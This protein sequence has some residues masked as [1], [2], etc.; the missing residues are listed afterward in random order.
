MYF[1]LLDV[2]RFLSS[3]AVFFH[4]TFAFHY[5]KLGVYLFFMISGFVIYFSLHKGLKEYAIGRFLRLYPLFWICITL[6]YL[7]TLFYGNNLSLDRYLIGLAM[8]NDGKIAQ[9]IDGSYWTLTFELLFYFYIAVFVKLFSAKKLEWFYISWLLI[10]FFSF[11]LSVDQHIIAKLL[12]VRFAPYF[13]FGGMLALLIDRYRVVDLKTKILY[14]GTLIAS[15]LLPVYV[16]AKLRAQQ[17]TISNFTASF[18]PDEM[19]IVE[20]FFILMPL[21]VYLSYFSFA[22]AK[23]FSKVCFILGGITYPLYLLHWKIGDTVI[24]A[25]GYTYGEVNY[26]SVAIATLIFA[27]SYVLSA[28][29]L[30]LRKFLK[31]KFF[32]GS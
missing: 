24:T 29:D 17:G 7:V 23:T 8:F 18:E 32:G 14:V 1:T 22:K 26:F 10:S 13:V 28:Y 30:T 19:I 4:H 16:S 25:N 20:L 21:A 15:A 9:L 5:G 3:V 31:R 6:T 12:S 11:F 27:V 2:L